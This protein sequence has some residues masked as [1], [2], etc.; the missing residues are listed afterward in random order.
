MFQLLIVDD[1]AHV[2]E[3]FMSTVDWKLI[4]VEQVYGAYSGQEA[5]AIL[6]R[7]TIDIVVTDIQ[8]PGMTGLQLAAEIQRRWAKTKCILLSGYSDFQYAKEAILHR[9][10]N[11][12]LKPITER[13]LTEA[14]KRVL[15]KLKAEWEEVVSKQ[16][17]AY[18]LKENLPLLRGHF[19]HDLL[20]GRRMD[21]QKLRDKMELLELPDLVGELFTIMAVRLDYMKVDARSLSLME[22]AIGNM[23]EEL[24]GGRLHIWNT[25]DAHDYLIFIMS[26]KR[27]SGEKENTVWIEKNAAM[28]QSAVNNYLKGKISI[29]VSR[30]GTFPNDVSNL[31]ERSVASFR[32][33]IGNVQEL[34]MRLDDVSQPSQVQTLQS[35]YEPPVLVHL[36]EAARWEEAERKLASVMAELNGRFAHSQEHLLQAYCTI[37]SAFTFIAHKNGQSLAALIGEEYDKLTKGVPFRTVQQLSEWSANVLKRIREDTVRETQHSRQTLINEIHSFIE[38]HISSDVTL[39]TIADHV[40]LHPVY[41]SKIYKLETGFNLSDYIHRIRMEKAEYMLKNSGDKM[42]EIAAALGYQRPHSFNHAFKKQFGMTPQEFRDRHTITK[43]KGDGDHE[44]YEA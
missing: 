13:D 39:Q 4:G 35:L 22:Y 19:L 17:M 15:D 28:L 2:V 44:N 1:E 20:L 31:Y 26:N 29:L 5:L 6:E 16:R 23:V 12:L 32:R 33:K 37:A 24:F 36:L 18:A 43:S 27:E 7:M 9:I 21:E 41:V 34:F 11:Y 10:E 8:M 30:W 42:Y 14:V 3:R 38:S 25:K 40:Y